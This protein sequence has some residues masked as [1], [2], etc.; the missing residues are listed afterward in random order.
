[1]KRWGHAILVCL[2]L[3]TLT[4]CGDQLYLEDADIPLSVALDMDEEGK[5]IVVTSAPV[6]REEANKKTHFEQS[7]ALSFRQNRKL[8]NS[9]S[10]GNVIS[11]KIQNLII[12]KQMLKR[13]NVFPILDVIFRDPKSEINART[14]VVDGSLEDLQNIAIQDKGRLGI[15]IRDTIDAAHQISSTVL[16]RVIDFRGQM[17]DNRVT[18]YLTE[19]RIR[20]QDY[21][22]TGTALLN[23]DG[24]YATSLNQNESS[25][26]LLL[27]HRTEYP[28]QLPFTAPPNMAPNNPTISQMNVSL[29]VNRHKISSAYAK[30]RFLFEFQVDL[31]ANLS[32]R[33]FP[34]DMKTERRKLEQAIEKQLQQKLERLIT[35]IQHHRLDPMGLG[36]V[37]QAYHYSIWKQV[38]N[39]WPETLAKANIRVTPHVTIKSYG[40]T[41]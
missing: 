35:K 6:F 5:I 32:E 19:M 40:I 30:G 28:L 4:G 38:Q 41:F 29:T 39:N 18:P 27:Q 10:Q 11:G 36:R 14:I 12:S 23:N 37:A 26:L 16:T 34:F 31:T 3:L 22:I 1:M 25:L 24:K 9:Q 17:L 2:S 21:A 33:T 13:I 15:A 20:G 7:T 8:L